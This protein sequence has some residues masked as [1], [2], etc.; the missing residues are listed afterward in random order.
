MKKIIFTGIVGLIAGFISG[1]G[2]TYIFCKEKADDNAYSVYKEEVEKFKN[3]W[4]NT[5]MVSLTEDTA[6]KKPEKPLAEIDSVN[7]YLGALKNA[8][9]VT[10]NK[11]DGKENEDMT[12]KAIMIDNE[13]EYATYEE[14]ADHIR[15]VVYESEQNEFHYDETDVETY[16]ELEEFDAIQAFGGE[17]LVRLISATMF[18]DG[19]EIYIYNFVNS[20]LYIVTVNADER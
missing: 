14:R 19:D 8:S 5:H 17:A 1:A 6:A 4:E 18:E 13:A 2:I 20:T 11:D 16:D 3:R 7:E 12:K 9:Y 15:Y 10:K